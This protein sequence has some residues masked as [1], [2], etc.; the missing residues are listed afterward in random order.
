[1]LPSVK[2]MKVLYLVLH[3]SRCAPVNM[4]NNAVQRGCAVACGERSPPNRWFVTNASSTTP[5]QPLALCELCY[6][7]CFFFLCII[8]NWLCKYLSLFLGIYYANMNNKRKV[9][10][11]IIIKVQVL[12]N[13]FD[14]VLRGLSITSK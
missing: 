5:P 10:M 2:T 14:L 4:L 13:K 9:I 12:S 8:Q 7:C 1:M 6:L 11:I 3:C